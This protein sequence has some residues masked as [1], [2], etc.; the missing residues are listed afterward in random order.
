MSKEIKKALSM[1]EEKER[2]SRESVEKAQEEITAAREKAASLKAALESAETAEQYATIAREIRDNEAMLEFYEKRTQGQAIT[3]EEYRAI[4]AEVK[5]AY[6]TITAAVKKD[7]AAEL[8]KLGTMLSVYDADIAEINAALT[9]A[10]QLCNRAPEQYNMLAL[11]AGN[12]IMQAYMAAYF[13]EK[14]IRT[15]NQG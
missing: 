13:R 5:R 14:A 4:T 15:I 2:K 7:T 12:T 11:S 10:A 1:I 6:E 8:Q 9:R 3:P